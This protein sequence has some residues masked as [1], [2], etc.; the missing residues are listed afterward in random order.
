MQIS[1]VYLYAVNGV[2]FKLSKYLDKII[3]K[4]F[5]LFYSIGDLQM[6]SNHIIGLQC[7]CSWKSGFNPEFHL[8]VHCEPVDLDYETNV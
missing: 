5:I 1:T 4:G 2:D 3:N 8:C 7:T 6:V